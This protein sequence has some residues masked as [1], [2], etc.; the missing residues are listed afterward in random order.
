MEDKIKMMH[1]R[2]AKEAFDNPETDTPGTFEEFLQG[3]YSDEYEKSN[4][5][6]NPNK[7]VVDRYRGYLAQSRPKETKEAPGLLGFVEKEGKGPYPANSEEDTH[8]IKNI[9]TFLHS[10]EMNK[11]I[12]K[13]LA[14]DS[15]K[16][17][18]SIAQ[19]AANVALRLISEIRKQREVSDEGETAIV[20][21]IAEDLWTVAKSL[22][23][24][25]VP[26]EFVMNSVDVA[27]KIYNQLEEQMQTGQQEQ[28]QPVEQ[29]QGEQQAPQ[30]M[31][32]Q[33]GD[34]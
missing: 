22:G 6:V 2:K 25:R 17:T 18:E 16:I 31:P 4:K 34:M 26:Q 13:Q 12:A 30:E 27:G 14:G 28:M 24:K 11:N 20:T 23:M 29:L 7:K 19:V 1:L 8:L 33:Q 32:S 21:I 10:D 3:Q 5:K 15:S 9:M